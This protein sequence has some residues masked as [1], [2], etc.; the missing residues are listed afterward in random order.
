MVAYNFGRDVPDVLDSDIRD[1][2]KDLAEFT[3]FPRLYTL[4]EDLFK[5]VVVGGNL[6][7][8]GDDQ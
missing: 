3:D 2:L 5:N 7:L 6:A 4:S 8:Q 1:M